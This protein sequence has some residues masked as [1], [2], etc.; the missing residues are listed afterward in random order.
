MQLLTLLTLLPAASAFLAPAHPP[1][2]SGIRSAPIDEPPVIPA[3]SAP[4]DSATAAQ[5]GKLPEM[6]ASL[7]F[8]SRPPMLDGSMAGDVGFD[9]LN[10]SSASKED[11]YKYRE[12]EI[13]HARLAMLAAAGWPVSELFDKGIAS[14]TGLQ[15]LVD[16]TDRAPSLLNGG[17]GKVSP[18]YWGFCLGLSAAI[19]LY[20]IQRKN[21]AKDYLPGD[22]GFDP[23]GLYPANPEDRFQMQLKE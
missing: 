21:T 17:L 9:P 23:L 16:A 11:L 22:L 4:A 8:L 15:P 7:P 13:K 3:D 5:L 18:L 1:L 2:S 6:S 19:D 12:A 10:F 20:G 14:F